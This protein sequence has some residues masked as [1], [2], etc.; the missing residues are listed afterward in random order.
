MSARG[1]NDAAHAPA[2]PLE[3]EA[4]VDLRFY[5]I[6][7]IADRLE[8]CPRT[9]LRWIKTGQLPVHRFGKVTRI[10]EADLLNFVAARRQPNTS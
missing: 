6:G 7:D 9:V 1:S 4:G 8:V 2:L 5:T 3:Q 10:L